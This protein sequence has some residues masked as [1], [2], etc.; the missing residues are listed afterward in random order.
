MTAAKTVTVAT[1]VDTMTVLTTGVTVTATTT[2]VQMLAMAFATVQ[3]SGCLAAICDLALEAVN[4][5]RR[6]H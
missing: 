6:R 4:V 2:H 3:T 1:W 5:Q